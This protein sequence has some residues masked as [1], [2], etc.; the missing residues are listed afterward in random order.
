MDEEQFDELVTRVEELLS[1]PWNKPKGRKRKLSLAD[2]VAIT[3]SYLR[4]D[5]IQEI[6]AERWG[7]SQER[8]S[9]M[10]TYLTPLIEKAMDEFISTEEDAAESV[11]D[12]VCLLDGSLGP[13]WSWQ[14][15]DEL[16]TRK[17]GTTGHNFQVVTDLGGEVR[18][19]S[20][21]VPGSVHDSVA[22]TQTPVA[23]ILEN[24]GGTIADK[25]Y[26][27]CGYVTPRKKP[28]GGELS[29]GD[30]RENRNISRLRAPVERAMA[31]I[32]SWR[33]LHTDYRRPLRT[34]LTSFRAAIG[35]FFFCLDFP[36]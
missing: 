26:Q 5:S 22:I 13:C 17:H 34:Y 36:F 9:E 25:G 8:V 10:V 21:P 12:R 23:R 33:I 24:S 14:E 28:K 30:K 16:W 27:G 3:V 29:I 20:D 1:E 19:I 35:L 4:Q 6:L 11:R 15:H 18:F 31:H 7:V 32:K 2:A